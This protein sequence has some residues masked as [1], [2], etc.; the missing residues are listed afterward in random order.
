[1]SEE[2]KDTRP[3]PRVLGYLTAKLYVAAD[4]EGIDR[5]TIEEAVQWLRNS[6]AMFAAYLEN[7]V[8]AAIDTAKDFAL[9]KQIRDACLEALQPLIGATTVTE[10]TIRY[11]VRL[12]L[13]KAEKLLPSSPLP[14]ITITAD[15]ND[16][17]RLTVR[18]GQA[19]GGANAVDLNRVAEFVAGNPA[20][21]PGWIGTERR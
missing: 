8:H 11:A 4:R 2:K 14:E 19:H 17:T 9:R 7:I 21:C 16:P 18:A 3:D 12:C 10:A 13:E 20:S 5:A 6:N 15:P 1:M